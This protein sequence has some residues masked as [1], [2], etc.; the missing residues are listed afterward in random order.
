MLKLVLYKK[1]VNKNLCVFDIRNSNSL[2]IMKGFS[3]WNLL[4]REF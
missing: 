2:C 4:D 3:A 1:K